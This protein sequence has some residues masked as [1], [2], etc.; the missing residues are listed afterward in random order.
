MNGRKGDSKRLEEIQMKDIELYVEETNKLQTGII[1]REI[2]NPGR[3][4]AFPP[5]RQ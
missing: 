4:S 2:K 3:S 5:G 1:F